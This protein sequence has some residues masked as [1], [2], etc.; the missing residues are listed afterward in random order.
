MTSNQ[1][2][3][4]ARVMTDLI[5]AD[6]I[7][8]MSEMEFLFKMRERYKIDTEHMIAAQKTD[9]GAAVNILKE[10][11]EPELK[12]LLIHLQGLMVS[13][14]YCAPEEAMLILALD[15]CLNPKHKHYCK[16]ISTSITN[17]SIDQKNIVYTETKYDEETNEQLK[18]SWRSLKNDF[19]MAGLRFVYMPKITKDFNEMN[20]EY[21]LQTIDFLA[22]SLSKEKREEIFKELRSITTKDFCDDFLVKKM[23]LDPIFDSDPS[24]LF[25]VC[26]SNDK[27]VYMHLALGLDVVKELCNFIDNYKEL[28]M[29]VVLPIEHRKE[30]RRFIYRGFHKALFDLLAFPGQKIESRLL[31]NPLQRNIY[32]MDLGESLSLPTGQLAL[33]MFIIQQSIFAPSHELPI[34]AVTV[35][36]KKSLEK[37]FQHIYGMMSDS[38]SSDYTKS[39]TPNLSHIKRAIKNISLLDNSD[40]YIPERKDGVL[41]IKL[42]PSKVLVVENGENILMS[43]SEMWRKL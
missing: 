27:I 3:A 16:L 34:D 37:T 6:D 23:G 24:I 31:I 25:Q 22:P 38:A 28:T 11:T 13:D 7:I 36:R 33:Y 9:F 39:L 20:P 30:N 2:I 35:N 32:F 10:L 19:G 17:I 8:D 5:K 4:L 15:Y 1:K 18:K 21:L 41:R 12:E 26:R 29:S 42:K 14:G 43:E 40:M